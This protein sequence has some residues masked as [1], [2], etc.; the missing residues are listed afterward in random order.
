AVGYAYHELNFGAAYTV[1]NNPTGLTG[2][3]PALPLF[4]NGS[5]QAGGYVQFDGVVRYDW[6]AVLAD[7]SL[8]GTPISLGQL[9]YTFT[10][11]G[12][13]AFS[14]TIPSTGALAAT[15][16]LD[17]VLEITGHFWLAGDPFDAQVTS[18]PEPTSLTLFA[19]AGLF[20]LRRRARRSL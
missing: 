19:A 3:T 13:G 4:I 11:L 2:S 1:S 8:S 10:Q 16:I 7:G 6:I 17:G 9:N 18:L 5:M 12:G 14:A 20:A 15:P